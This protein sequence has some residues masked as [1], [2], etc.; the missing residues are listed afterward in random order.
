MGNASAKSL[1]LCLVA[2]LFANTLSAQQTETNSAKEANSPQPS[3][4]TNVSS[5]S[6]LLYF[7]KGRKHGEQRGQ[8]DPDAQ[9]RS[10][11]RGPNHGPLDR[12]AQ[13]I[14]TP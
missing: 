8:Y 11:P 6:G 12:R 2:L 14:K 3:L 5:G 9:Q 1:V 7:L 13:R 4:T 10:E